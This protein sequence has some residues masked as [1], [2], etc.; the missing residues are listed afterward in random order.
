[1][2]SA[3]SATLPNNSVNRLADGLGRAPFSDMSARKVLQPQAP[4]SPNLSVVPDRGVQLSQRCPGTPSRNEWR[5][6]RLPQSTTL[7]SPQSP[8][9][10]AASRPS[11]YPV[12]A[13]KK[14]MPQTPNSLNNHRSPL[15][16]HRTPAGPS[17]GL[18]P[19]VP[20]HVLTSPALSVPRLRSP[21]GGIAVN[22]DARQQGVPGTPSLTLNRTP[23][24]SASPDAFGRNQV[25]SAPNFEA[26]NDFGR[27]GPIMEESNV[28]ISINRS[29][30]VA[31]PQN[32]VARFYHE[33]TANPG[34][35]SSIVSTP[36][37][38][39]AQ[40][41]E[42]RRVQ[43]V[44]RRVLEAV[45]ERFGLDGEVQ[46]GDLGAVFDVVAQHAGHRSAPMDRN[47]DEGGLV[48]KPFIM[49]LEALKLWPPE[50]S[51]EDRS[52]IFHALLVPNIAAARAVLSERTAMR[53]GLH[54]RLFREG[55]EC[56]PFNL[57]DF[58]VPT[59]LM[60]S[61][62][63]LPLEKFTSEQRNSVTEAVATTF[64]L[65]K[66]GVDKAKD[67]FICGLL[68]LEE[69][70]MGLPR[71]LPHVLV[72]DAVTRVIRRGAPLMS[73]EEWQR[74]VL[75]VR[76]PQAC[77]QQVEEQPA[78]QEIFVE[79]TPRSPAPREHREIREVGAVS[80]SPTPSPAILSRSLA[81]DS[82]N[83]G[84][85]GGA[86]DWE[87]I[88]GQDREAPQRQ[89]V[90]AGGIPI[91]PAAQSRE[92][93]E[94]AVPLAETALSGLPSLSSPALDHR[95][96]RP[97]EQWA[98]PEGDA[99]VHMEIEPRA[100]FRGMR[101]GFDA[102]PATEPL[103][104]RNIRSEEPV[105]FALP[106]T[107]ATGPARV[108]NWNTACLSSSMDGGWRGPASPSPGTSSA[109]EPGRPNVSP[110][111]IVSWHKADEGAGSRLSWGTSGFKQK[112]ELAAAATKSSVSEPSI[113]MPGGADPVAWINIDLHHECGGPYLASAFMRC[114][115]L[116]VD[117]RKRGTDRSEPRYTP[118]YSMP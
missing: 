17:Q 90:S 3:G 88:L 29:S 84:G 98:A 70:Q 9:Q 94:V 38:D 69:I 117:A 109:A 91:T 31:T 54:R 4:G 8:Q 45:Q 103:P 55:F 58:P 99:D 5:G 13:S 76:T 25:G 112:L 57:P 75:E 43:N 72:E 95:N 21:G 30:E 110:E 107:A 71:L 62:L 47:L 59:H 1:M 81:V 28:L 20:R 113:L 42:K 102:M 87:S 19:A 67:F 79:Q 74:L 14:L 27:G 40:Y 60:T 114:C 52:E 34:S 46:S 85:G 64:C 39:V 11:G 26:S 82:T 73:S 80:S 118:L 7:Q 101:S 100:Q 97:Q 63:R 111:E 93:R 83:G 24:V 78:P 37:M 61:A 106:L 86:V 48:E 56:V 15:D 50:L 104:C 12:A 115:Q 33:A 65:E 10:S 36:R 44:L 96:I 116:Y 66:T 77:G 23:K 35:F 53:F 16:N 49:A 18:R 2:Y 6:T 68:S 22:G 108:V 51:P 105:S 89:A 32:Y 92:L 41:W